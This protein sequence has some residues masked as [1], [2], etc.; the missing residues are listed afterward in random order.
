MTM[1][2]RLELAKYFAERN[3]NLGAEIGVA[4]GEYSK[5]LCEANPKLIL[6]CIDNW[7]RRKG[8]GDGMR[9]VWRYRT[10]QKILA[11]YNTTLIRKNSMD[12]LPDFGNLSLDF[13]YIDANHNSNYVKQDIEGWWKKIRVGGIL[14]GHD[15][16]VD[17]IY[18]T[19]IKDVIEKYVDE[20][21]LIINLTDWGNDENDLCHLSWWV[22]KYAE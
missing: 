20:N 16:S 2:N 22:E 15:F 3:L 19:D 10:A 5:I 21:N 1:Q 12:A 7:G 9:G 14:A 18:K 8:F 6:Y 17:P 11:P 13:V 4:S